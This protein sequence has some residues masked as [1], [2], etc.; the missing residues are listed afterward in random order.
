MSSE[1][2]WK[3]NFFHMLILK[4]GRFR[5][6]K[7]KNITFAKLQITD[8]ARRKWVTYLTRDAAQ[9]AQEKF[10]EV[11]SQNTRES[12]ASHSHNPW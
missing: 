1:L 2:V 9:A 10:F 5:Y 12:W 8:R 11:Q 7:P 6:I 3:V 4:S